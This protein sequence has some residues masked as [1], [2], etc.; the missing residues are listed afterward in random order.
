MGGERGKEGGERER[1]ERKGEEEHFLH[2][3]DFPA[4]L[5]TIYVIF[6]IVNHTVFNVIS[7]I[8]LET[9]TFEYIGSP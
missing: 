8:L 9:H 5:H 2:A 4:S 6:V 3:T 1:G 7:L